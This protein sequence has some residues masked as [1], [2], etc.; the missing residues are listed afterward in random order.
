[1]FDWI[2]TW[3][4]AVWSGVTDAIKAFVHFLVRGLY[5][6]LHA[7]FIIAWDAWAF[8]WTCAH[9]LA[10]GLRTLANG[11]WN[12]AWRVI[13]GIIPWLNDLIQWVYHTTI[14]F[15][16]AV[17]RNISAYIDS[18]VHWVSNLIDVVREWVVNDVY[19]PLAKFID[20][21]LGWIGRE[22]ATMWHYFTH[23]IELADLLFWHIVALLEK[24]AWDAARV[25][26]QF[27]LSLVIR[28]IVQF[29][30]L[31][32]NVIDAVL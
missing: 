10:N 27:F 16:D 2:D 14:S 5:G 24:Y 12:F 17:Q 8:F 6:Y 21:A 28:N 25:L 29:V 22:G 9:V 1:M 3:V 30:T 11:V 20:Q 18:V 23:L 32:E 19:N 26:G 15:I 4:N 13:H 7:L 31:I